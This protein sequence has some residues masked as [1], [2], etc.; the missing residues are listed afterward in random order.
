MRPLLMDRRFSD[1][2]IPA[3][4]SHTN[5]TRNRSVS[6]ESRGIFN[7]LQGW[8][9]DT[10]TTRNRAVSVG[11]L[12]VLNGVVSG[13][14]HHAVRTTERATSVVPRQAGVELVTQRALSEPSHRKDVQRAKTPDRKHL[15]LSRV[16]LAKITLRSCGP[17]CERS[18]NCDRLTLV[19][20]VAVP[21]V[22]FL[23]ST[24]MQRGEDITMGLAFAGF[25]FAVTVQSPPSSLSEPM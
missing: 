21:S 7:V 5:T 12:T 6:P 22:R 1:P 4:P 2:V 20:P 18:W 17:G 11:Q 3:C 24:Q 15:L 9:R 19:P 13:N 10:D 14:D 16:L 25:R 8:H 23:V